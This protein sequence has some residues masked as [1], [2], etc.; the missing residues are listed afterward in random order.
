MMAA[1]MLPSIAPLVLLVRGNRV[2]L[3]TAYLAVWAIT[4]LLP[5]AAMRLSFYPAPGIVLAVA[6]IYE[7]TPLKTACLRGC[8]NTT[9]FLM[10]HYRS[11]PFRPCSSS[12]AR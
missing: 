10:Q 7:L 9:T 2:V 3:A 6:G 1:M 12:P 8:T 4:G 5:W 11:G